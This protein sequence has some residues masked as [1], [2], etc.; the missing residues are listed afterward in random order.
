MDVFTTTK[1]ENV[2][3]LTVQ[4]N[5]K[6]IF[7]G[8]FGPV[9]PH[10]KNIYAAFVEAENR[11]VINLISKLGQ[12]WEQIDKKLWRQAIIANKKKYILKIEEKPGVFYPTVPMLMYAY[13]NS[14]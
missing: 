1:A 3:Y 14:H 7:E 5:S 6:Y 12:H 10:S 8:Y 4:G 2:F 9:F 11:E 13:S